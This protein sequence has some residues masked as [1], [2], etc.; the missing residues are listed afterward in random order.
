MCVGGGGGGGDKSMDMLKQNLT[1]LKLEW[2]SVITS[3]GI[4]PA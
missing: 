4:P 1:H 2:H 3:I